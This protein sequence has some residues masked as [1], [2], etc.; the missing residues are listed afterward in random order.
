M[1]F[2]FL[3]IAIILVGAVNSFPA[4]TNKGISKIQSDYKTGKINFEYQLLQKFY[5]GFDKS[6]LASEYADQDLTP[7]KSGT[8]IVKEF[9]DHKGELSN[10]AIEEISHFLNSPF[11]KTSTSSVYTTPSGK[12][13]ITYD[14]TGANAVPTADNDG[15]GIPD[16]VEWAGSYFDYVWHFEIDSLGYLAPPIGAGQYQVSFENMGYYGYTEPIS[17][18]LTHIVLHNN[19]LG[20]PTN[21]DPEGNQKGAAKVTAAHEFK[22]ATQIMYNNWNEPGWFL[23][24]DAT[25]MEDIAYTQVNDYY[26]Y[27]P[28]SQIAYPNRSFDGGEGY[29]DCIWMHYLSQKFGVL[30]N[31][32]IWERRKVFSLELIYDNFNNI[33]AQ[34]SYTFIKG[35]EE[36]FTW[37]YGCGANVS[38]LIRSYKEADNYPTPTVCKTK[39]IPDSSAGCGNTELSANYFYYSSISSSKLV[40]FSYYGTPSVDQTLEFIIIYKNNTEEVRDTSIGSSGVINYIL[41]K[42]LSDISAIIVIPIFITMNS[43]NYSN[44]LKVSPFSTAEFI[45]TPLKDIETNSSRIVKAIIVTEDNIALTDSL[46]LFY[47]TGN[48]SYS[49]IKMI[50]TGNPNEYSASIPGYQ[51]G[52]NVNYYFSIY[53]LPGEYTYLPGTAPSVPF[54]YYVGIDI[55][56]PIINHVPIV[57]KTKYDFPFNLFAEVNDNIGID[58]VFL[59]YN[60]NGGSYITKSFINY[61]DSIYYVKIIPDSS[62]INSIT[63]FGYRITAID[64][65]SRHNMKTF[66][67]AGYQQLSIVSGFRYISS[68]NK[69]IP[70]HNIFGVKDTITITDSINIGDI[71]IIFHALHSRFSDLS[72]RISSPFSNIGYLFKNPGLGTSFENA[73]DPDITFEQD[74]YLSMKNFETIDTSAITGEYR[75]DT[76]NLS[77][78]TNNNAKGN[79]ILYIVDNRAGETGNLVDWGLEIIPFGAD[80][81]K[82]SVLPN[83]FYLSQNYPNPFNPST[84]IRYSIL[85]GAN[86]EMKIF[87]ILGREIAVLVKGYKPAGNYEVEFSI[88]GKGIPSG[89][90]F[91]KLTAGDFSSVKK[92][93]ILK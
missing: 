31:R 51:L 50:S 1:K 26:N 5:Y 12:F 21:T 34:Y 45:F 38:P 48:S 63:N 64:N 65:S 22:H 14:V 44:S 58:S 19:F 25:W 66:P 81:K 23:E 53:D 8:E 3:L 88:A 80:I 9:H 68:H 40:K 87:D 2:Y 85:N 29:E 37:N 47:G 32:Q 61:R 75:P 20:F 84:R 86:V 17:G 39:S 59:E 79:W 42:K 90:Y 54:T 27:L 7:L 55:K 10:K 89:I 56:P 74:V 24:M 36:Y 69:A 62:I 41:P 57:Q 33:L 46:R 91:Y 93:V 4:G 76:L 30:I 72:V 28:S 70:D 43:G 60:I 13:A 52:T 6:K 18:Q 67:S 78:F 71:K 16:Y 77:N 82:D 83:K 15:D 35:Y 11:E 73:K 49:S 92:L